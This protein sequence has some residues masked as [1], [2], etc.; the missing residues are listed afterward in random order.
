MKRRQLLQSAAATL[1]RPSLRPGRARA[2][3][4]APGVPC[5]R[6]RCVED[7]SDRPKARPTPAASTSANASASFR[8]VRAGPFPSSAI[9]RNLSS[10]RQPSLARVMLRLHTISTRSLPPAFRCTTSGHVTVGIVLSGE[11]STDRQRQIQPLRALGRGADKTPYKRRRRWGLTF[12]QL[13][14]GKSQ[15]VCV[16]RTRGDE[17]AR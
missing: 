3:L 17:P 15:L 7:R 14:G 6:T 5:G 16:P 8:P 10:R 4:R 12:G 13:G 2:A 9:R 1:A 11:T